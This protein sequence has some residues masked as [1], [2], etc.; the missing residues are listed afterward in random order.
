MVVALES[1]P[2]AATPITT[3][4]PTATAVPVDM[5]ATVPPA[6]A[7]GAMPPA[8]TP[9]TAPMLLKAAAA[10]GGTAEPGIATASVLD[11]ATEPKLPAPN[12]TVPPAL[13]APTAPVPTLMTAGLTI[14][15]MKSVPRMRMVACGT[16]N[17]KAA[18]LL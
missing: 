17:W 10:A 6:A 3:T 5:P 9:G 16:R 12:T 13:D 15:T 18:W 7:P 11:E 2:A 1:L 14:A 4:A 8:T